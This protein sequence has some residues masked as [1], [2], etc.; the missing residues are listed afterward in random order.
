MPFNFIAHHSCRLCSRHLFYSDGNRD[1]EEEG[2][3]GEAKGTSPQ[4]ASAES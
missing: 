3:M 1:E 2:E 4:R